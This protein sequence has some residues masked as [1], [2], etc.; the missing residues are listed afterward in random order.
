MDA[1]VA[2]MGEV[3]SATLYLAGAIF[4]EEEWAVI[5]AI[6][7][8]MVILGIVA[9]VVFLR[10]V[11]RVVTREEKSPS[12]VAIVAIGLLIGGVWAISAGVNELSEMRV[13]SEL[14]S[15]ARDVIDPV[16]GLPS[17][18]FG[19][20]RRLRAGGPD[21]DAWVIPIN[22]TQY[23]F[24]RAAEVAE[25]IKAIVDGEAAAFEAAGWAVTRYAPITDRT[26]PGFR[27]DRDGEKSIALRVE[28][29]YHGLEY[30]VTDPECTDGPFKLELGRTEVSDFSTTLPGN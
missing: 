26:T 18:A 11:V 30:V 20:G 15:E 2:T 4:T 7:V 13:R 6:F 1:D 17:E 29:G 8:G 12:D 22:D 21:C 16:S 28:A 9:I 25:P 5:V 27:A 24:G 3:D 23:E 19:D 14:R 10:S